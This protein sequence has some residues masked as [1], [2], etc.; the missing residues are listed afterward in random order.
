VDKNSLL[1]KVTLG[2]ISYNRFHYLKATLESAKQCIHY[3]NLEWIVVDGVSKEPG[4]VSYLKNCNWI[5]K[6]IIKPTRF[7]DCLNIILEEAS[8]DYVLL[9]PDDMQFIV[10]GEWLGDLIEIFTGNRNIGAIVLNLQSKSTINKFFGLRRWINLKSLFREVLYNGFKFRFQSV[11]RGSSGMSVRTYGRFK[12]GFVPDGI[13]TLSRT[14]IWRTLGPWKKSNPK[15]GDLVAA[16]DGAYGDMSIRAKSFINKMQ[17]AI[18]LLPVA[19]DIVDDKIGSKAKVRGDKRY[20][21]YMKPPDGTFYY[22]I[23]KQ[24][25]VQHLFQRKTPL[26][27]EEFVKP[28]GYELPFDQKGNLLKAPIDESIVNPI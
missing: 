15:H 1:P 21:V 19:A 7:I 4:L 27:F 17:R 2:F 13:P 9:W 16:D 10:E 11:K 6:L 3:P 12:L 26:S 24:E 28:I 14:A 18:M 5:D 22:Q 25:D 8:G 20:G 23:Y